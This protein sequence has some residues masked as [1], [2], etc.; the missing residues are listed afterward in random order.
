MILKIRRLW[1]GIVSTFR[2]LLVNS[3]RETPDREVINMV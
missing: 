3:D 2:T 1:G